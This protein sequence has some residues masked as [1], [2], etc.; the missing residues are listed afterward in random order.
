MDDDNPIRQDLTGVK[1]LKRVSSNRQKFEKASKV[2]NTL[3][4]NKGFGIHGED[5]VH[6]NLSLNETTIE[7]DEFEKQKDR[8]Y[9][10][11]AAIDIGTTFSGYAYSSHKDFMKDPLKVFSHLWSAANYISQKTSTFILYDPED[12]F[13][14]FGSDA[15]TRYIELLDQ[16]D[17]EKWKAF[18]NF[19]MKLYEKNVTLENAELLLED[20]QGRKKPALTVFADCIRSLKDSLFNNLEEQGINISTDKVRFIL[21][22]PAIWNDKSRG[23]MINA[24]KE[25]GIQKEHLLLSLEP[26]AAAVL[27]KE[28]HVDE[29]YKFGSEDLINFDFCSEF[30]VADLGGGTIDITTNKILPFGS[31][32]E[33]KSARGGDYGGTMVDREFFDFLKD[34]IGSDYDDFIREH[35]SEFHDLRHDLEIK[36]RQTGEAT[37]FFVSLTIAPAF[38][39]KIDR[40][41]MKEHNDRIKI[42]H[43]KLQIP[44]EFFQSFFSKPIQ[45]ILTCLEEAVADEI[46]SILLVGGFANSKLIYQAVK[47]KFPSKHVYC[48]PDADLSVL[49]GAV[50]YGHN[51]DL[52]A[53][54]ISRDW[55]GV[56]PDENFSPVN[57][58]N[59][60]ND[61]YLLT[62]KGHPIT[63]DEK[64]YHRF[65]VD[66]K[67]DKDT[68]SLNIVSSAAD[69][70]PTSTTEDLKRVKSFDLP[71]PSPKVAALRIIDLI[72]KLKGTQFDFKARVKS[73][74]PWL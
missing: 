47:E 73:R 56:I 33:I 46:K 17:A 8:T 62:Q 63:M 53:S 57:L 21:T 9:L 42:S 72:V 10:Y 48:P 18:Y 64:F 30:V 23:F 31:L 13:Y 69:C 70:L 67:C 65:I 2:K 16:E 71:L 6:Q 27:C 25:A 59:S 45:G 32:K 15:E 68:I 19:K 49:K 55:L 74:S 14:S 40:S 34:C 7:E 54:R 41:K 24:A 3:K 26:E 12:K 4:T 38:E 5:E 35:L 52:V 36:K 60:K 20:D 1:Q 51:P 29:Y 28:H 66:K 43:G 61:F 50:I 22:V 11:V 39:Q 58:K 37:H 44:V